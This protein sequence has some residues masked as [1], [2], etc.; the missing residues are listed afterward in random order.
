MA[1]AQWFV[2]LSAYDAAGNLLFDGVHHYIYDAENRIIS[3]DNGA[4]TYT[5]D[6]RGRRVAKTAGASVTDFIYDREGHVMLNNPS[7]PTFIE[8][9]AAGRH[10]GTYVMNSAHT[11]TVLYYNHADWLGTERARTDLSGTACEKIC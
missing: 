11:D 2:H 1:I 4:T 5:Y 7:T 3:V 6:A 10:L 9:Y 8:M